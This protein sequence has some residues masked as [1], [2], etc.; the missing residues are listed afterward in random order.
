MLAISLAPIRQTHTRHI[1]PAAYEVPGQTM[2]DT[3]H[4]P[5]RD[6]RQKERPAE[7]G[8]SVFGCD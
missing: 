7:A 3:Q 6:V 2:P 8:L 5:A 4:P 1:M